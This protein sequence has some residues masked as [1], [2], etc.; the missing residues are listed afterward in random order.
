MRPPIVLI[1]LDGSPEA[2]YALPQAEAAARS[3]GHSLRLLGIV[4]PTPAAG[5]VAPSPS[6]DFLLL[7]RQV[8][9]EDY[10]HRMARALQQRGLM[11]EVLVLREA[12]AIALRTAVAAPEVVLTVMVRPQA[13]PQPSS[14]DLAQAA[15]EAAAGTVQVVQHQ[16]QPI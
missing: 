13:E 5:T 1:P 4:D 6:L 14:P 10:L 9:L 12:P 16:L 3:L 2:E 7:Q 15:I 8:E 11:T